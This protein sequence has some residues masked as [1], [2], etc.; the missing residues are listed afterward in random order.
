MTSFKTL[1]VTIAVTGACMASAGTAATA[2]DQ[3]VTNEVIFGSGNING[4]FTTDTNAAEGIELGLRGKLRF[5]AA[6]NPQNTFN[7]NGDG[8]YSFDAGLPPTGFGFAPGSSSTGVWNF[9]WSINSNVNG[10]GAALDAF[11]YVLSLDGDTGAGTNFGSFDPINVPTADH[12]IG[13]NATGNG[14]GAVA[15]NGTEYTALI[16]GN[17]L[18]QNSWNYEFFDTLFTELSSFNG[19]DDGIYTIVLSAFEKG[20]TNQLASTSID[21]IVGSP[22]PIPLPAG[23]P[24]ALAGIG[25]LFAV[26]RRKRT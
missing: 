4:S 9:E 8:T 10:N 26:G 18:A 12:G 2:F 17:N 7:S 20:T 21:V 3:N 19:N 11:D 23:L 13:T 16:A 22:A 6:N 15:A 14:G 1:A 5:D 24:L 25:A